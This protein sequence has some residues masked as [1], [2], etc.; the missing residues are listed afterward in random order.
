VI[1]A[2]TTT[3]P[4]ARFA[5]ETALMAVVAQR[6]HIS[7]AGIAAAIPQSAIG[8]HRPSAV[9]LAESTSRLA[10][11]SAVVVDDEPQA[12]AA[13]AAGAPC[14]KLKVDR[15]LERVRRIARAVPGT[16]L[17]LDANRGWPRRSVSAMLGELADLPIDF[18]EEPCEDTL[19]LLDADLP[20]AVALDESLVG[21]ERDVLA[22]ALA[23]RR[24][25]ALVL[26]PTL[27]GGF[28]PCLELAAMARAHDVRSI[29]THALEGPI[30]TAACRE[31]A[32]AVIGGP[33]GVADHPAL[34]RFAEAV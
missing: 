27:L 34:E 15:D 30:G 20:I 17:R 4:A 11:T 29:V 31:L 8:P 24:L 6:L 2:R 5:I 9:L 21:I 28:A 3:A 26:K 12:R 18:V 33:H 22:R 7:V 19:E 23:S 14:L 13:I 16:R 25:A 1:A 32:R 10:S